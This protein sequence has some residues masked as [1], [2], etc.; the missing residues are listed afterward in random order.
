MPPP[1]SSPPLPMSNPPAFFAAPSPSP[2]TLSLNQLNS[3]SL[4]IRSPSPSP[5]QPAVSWDVLRRQARQLENDC[6]SKLSQFSRLAAQLSYPFNGPGAN[7]FGSQTTLNGGTQSTQDVDALERELEEKLEKLTFIVSGMGAITDAAPARPYSPSPSTSTSQLS[8]STPSPA[9]N[10]HALNRHRDILHEFS[11]EFSRSRQTA[12]TARERVQ[13]L[14]SQLAE[15]G[16][17]PSGGGAS[18]YARAG[19]YLLTERG[20]IEGVG[21]A[22]DDVVRWAEEAKDDLGKQRG[23][24]GGVERRAGG[25]VS[26]FP[27]LNSLISNISTKRRQDALVLS[28][29][30]GFLTFLLLVWMWR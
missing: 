20:R 29:L 13:L 2:P 17:G 8:S 16:G 9:A 24:L 27:A 22:A 21:S 7:S 11:K 15:Y 12:R 30:V 23:V 6:E 19:D 25:I 3:N 10:L 18:T 26:R 5:S 1:F 28:G 14:R 4:S